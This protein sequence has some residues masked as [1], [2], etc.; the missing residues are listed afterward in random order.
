MRTLQLTHPPEHGEDV[1]VL[2]QLLGVPV[3]GEYDEVAA[4][5]VYRKKLELGY[6][7][8]DHAAGDLLVS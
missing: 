1:R 6:L 2:Q 8:P 5:A 7:T 3:T 4:N